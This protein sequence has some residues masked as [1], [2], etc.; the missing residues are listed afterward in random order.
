MDG[1]MNN[2]V[3]HNIFMHHG[4]PIN[5]GLNLIGCGFIDQEDNDPKHTSKMYREG[6]R[7]LEFWN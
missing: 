3:Y 7:N 2:K 4:I 5:S 6:K 1:I